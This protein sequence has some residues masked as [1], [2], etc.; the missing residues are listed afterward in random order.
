MAF[1]FKVERNNTPPSFFRFGGNTCRVGITQSGFLTV[2]LADKWLGVFTA[3]NA[4]P[5]NKTNVLK[6]E[7]ESTASPAT[8]LAITPSSVMPSPLRD[9]T[10]CAEDSS[11]TL[12]DSNSP[13]T[14][15]TEISVRYSTDDYNKVF[16]TAELDG[17]II[18]SS[19]NKII[20]D[21]KNTDLKKTI[22]VGEQITLPNYSSLTIMEICLFP[23]FI[24]DTIVS[25]AAALVFDYDKTNLPNEYLDSSNLP[26]LFIS[27]TGNSHSYPLI[28]D[29]T[30]SVGS[31]D[32][33]LLYIDLPSAGKKLFTVK[34][35][36]TEKFSGLI[37]IIPRKDTFIRSNDL[38]TADIISIPINTSSNMTMTSS[39]NFVSANEGHRFEILPAGI[40]FEIH[41]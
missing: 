13:F 35:I 14:Q 33:D 32:E 4:N 27:L 30:Y 37:T 18:E 38:I 19:E 40:S 8:P 20:N 21:K 10:L 23:I 31:T 7:T 6:Q 11:F 12:S 15:Q 25:A 2:T 17:I 22:L 9:Y 41:S 28:P 24:P 5:K 26:H 36:R 1:I 3:V 16:F 34:F 29:I 39:T